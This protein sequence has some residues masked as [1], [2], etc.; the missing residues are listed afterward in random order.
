V[1]D[2][3]F[4]SGPVDKTWISGVFP[5]RLSRAS[6][7][8]GGLA[9]SNKSCKSPWVDQSRCRQLGR[10]VSKL[11]HNA[12]LSTTWFLTGP[13]YSALVRIPF[14]PTRSEIPSSSLIRTRSSSFCGSVLRA[15]ESAGVV[16]WMHQCFAGAPY[17]AT[18]SLSMFARVGGRVKGILW[19]RISI[20]IPRIGNRSPE[21]N[22]MTV[23]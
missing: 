3:R 5:L 21:R 13:H 17:Q 4:F 23:Q 16:G 6:Y 10:S 9:K 1:S 11:Q 7:V 22:R 12:T 2:G 15:L 19:C 20:F 14:W 18:W 8:A